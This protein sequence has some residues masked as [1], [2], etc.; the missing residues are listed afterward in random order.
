MVSIDGEPEFGHPSP[1]EQI[2]ARLDELRHRLPPWAPFAAVG[3]IALAVAGVVVLRPAPGAPELRIPMAAPVA[4]PTTTAP[5]MVVH[6]AGAVRRPGV[7]RLDGRARLADAVV[8]AGGAV[9]DADLDRVNLAAP[10]V[11]GTH[12]YLPLIGETT[13]VVLDPGTGGV[14]G[15]GPVDLNRAGPAQLETLTGIGPALAEAIIEHRERT[16]PF[17]VVD[18]LLA[19]SGIGPA[20]LDRIRDEVIVG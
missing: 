13:A 7:I 5:E 9:A 20:K 18:D 12:Y 6:V 19:V 10:L 15:D 8:A 16:G 14:A 11:D 1:A 4:V 3:L 17:A 2:G